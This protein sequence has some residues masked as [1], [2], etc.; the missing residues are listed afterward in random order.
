MSEGDGKRKTEMLFC[1]GNVGKYE[2]LLKY[3][4]HISNISIVQ[5]KELNIIEPQLNTAE[6]IALHKANYAYKKL[7]QPIIVHDGALIIKELKDF[8]GPYTKYVSQTIGCTGILKL[9]DG[10]ADRSSALIGCLVFVD[11]NG[12]SHIFTDPEQPEWGKYWGKIAHLHEN[13][14]MTGDIYNWSSGN[15]NE[16]LYNIFVPV[17]IPGNEKPL[18]QFSDDEITHLQMCIKSCYQDFANWLENN[19]KR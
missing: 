18:T 17:N 3:T 5:N 1:S 13:N 14:K 7:K 16:N 11:E 6:E 19:Y 9:L 8:P 4:R 10:V 15:P 12:K 2:L